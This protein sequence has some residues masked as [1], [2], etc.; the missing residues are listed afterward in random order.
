M[1]AL[2][3]NSNNSTVNSKQVERVRVPGDNEASSEFDDSSKPQGILLTPGDCLEE[4]AMAMQEGMHQI[5]L[6]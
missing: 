2:R 1:S 6:A 4:L 5:S 3:T